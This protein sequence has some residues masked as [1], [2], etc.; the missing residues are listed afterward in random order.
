MRKRLLLMMFLLLP[1]VVSRAATEINGI[2]YNLDSGN[3]T[4]EVTWE[5]DYY[6][7]SVTIPKTV[8][9]SGVDY[10]VTSIGSAAFYECS[11]LTDI[12]IPNSVTS[13]EDNA[14]YRCI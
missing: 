8:T 1:L 4:A 12:N 2:Y 7:G 14:F 6:T 3:K 10:S 9:Y 5:L 13:I 11:G